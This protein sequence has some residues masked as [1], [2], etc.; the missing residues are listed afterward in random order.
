MIVE[1]L[2]ETCGSQGSVPTWGC[3]GV[4]HGRMMLRLVGLR[5]GWGSRV[6]VLDASIGWGPLGPSTPMWRYANPVYPGWR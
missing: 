4:I 1:V 3:V 6:S 2:G 5:R